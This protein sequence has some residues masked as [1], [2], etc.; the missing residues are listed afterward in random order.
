MLWALLDN[1]VKYGGGAPVRVRVTTDAGAGLVK[2]TITDGGPGVPEADRVHLFERY[3]RGARSEDREGT[4]L[5]LYVGRALAVANGGELALR[6]A[7]DDEGA[8]FTLTLPAEAP[9]E[10]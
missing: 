2:T 5:G 6:P 1:A 9:T 3:A 7:T 10:G 4:G 8:A